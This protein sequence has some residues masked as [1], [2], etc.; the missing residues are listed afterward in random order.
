MVRNVC[1]IEVFA[2]LTEKLNLIAGVKR[3]T[4]NIDLAA[5]AVWCDFATRD[6]SIH[7]IYWNKKYTIFLLVY[8]LS[9]NN[10]LCTRYLKIKLS[11]LKSIEWLC[12]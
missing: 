4:G 9:E 7:F 5:K 10:L 8:G 1:Y 2:I 12:H 3:D 11:L 6:R